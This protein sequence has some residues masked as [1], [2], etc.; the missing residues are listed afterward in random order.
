MDFEKPAERLG[1][2]V[3]EYMELIELFIETGSKDLAELENAAEEKN[4]KAVI[5]RSHSIKGASGNLGLVEVYEVSKEIE[6][7]AINNSIDSIEDRILQ[8]KQLMENI[9]TSSQK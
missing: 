5:E 3:E 6:N 1:L 7:M 8:I 2:N 9:V 4:I